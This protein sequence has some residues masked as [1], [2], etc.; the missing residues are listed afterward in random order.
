MLERM[1]SAGQ[2]RS[3]DSQVAEQLA[4]SCPPS[5]CCMAGRAHGPSMFTF[6]SYLRPNEVQANT[7]PE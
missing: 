7:E 1:A 3:A 6:I 2:R 4:A 5:R